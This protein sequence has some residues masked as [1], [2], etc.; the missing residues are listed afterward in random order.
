M[1]A[2]YQ[3]TNFCVLLMVMSSTWMVTNLISFFWWSWRAMHANFH[4]FK[5]FGQ[6][7]KNGLLK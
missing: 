7:I 2:T 5:L 6:K 3:S 1:M 4:Q